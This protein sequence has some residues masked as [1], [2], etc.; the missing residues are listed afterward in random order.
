MPGGWTGAAG[1]S[2]FIL[3]SSSSTGPSLHRS[4]LQAFHSLY[5]GGLK[6]PLINFQNSCREL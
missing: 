3:L 4:Q 5:T 2:C 1:A 6:R